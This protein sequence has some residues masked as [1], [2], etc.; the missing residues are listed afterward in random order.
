MSLNTRL[1]DRLN[2]PVS[3][4]ALNYNAAEQR[5][6]TNDKKTAY[7]LHAGIPCLLPEAAIALQ[8]AANEADLNEP[9]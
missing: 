8:T 3:G 1:L 9:D 2:C 4:Q 6:E 5:L 7:P